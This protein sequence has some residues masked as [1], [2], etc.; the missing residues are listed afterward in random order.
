MTSND[1]LFF[2]PIFP[3]FPQ[4]LNTKTLYNATRRS[5]STIRLLRVLPTPASISPPVP[6]SFFSLPFV[7][8]DPNV[9]HRCLS[10]LRVASSSVSCPVHRFFFASSR[11]RRLAA[12]SLSL[13]L[14]RPRRPLGAYRRSSRWRSRWRARCYRKT[15][16]RDAVSPA[17]RARRSA[18]LRLWVSER[19]SARRRP[20][21]R[22]RARLRAKTGADRDGF[23]VFFAC[24][25]RAS[26]RMCGLCVDDAKTRRAETA[27]RARFSE[28][29]I[30]CVRAVRVVRRLQT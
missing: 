30:N 27:S 4:V 10:P 22:A 18:R 2:L 26:R 8:R 20:R 7:E 21:T 15:L 1:N 13:S 9:R 14:A 24:S 25:I 11:P 28:G 23:V 17:T 5:R 6:A 29:G 3:N 12:A 19:L 16:S